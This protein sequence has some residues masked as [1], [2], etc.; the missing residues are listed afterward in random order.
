MTGL[1]TNL[2]VRYII[3]DHPAQ[4]IK[5]TR[6]IDQQLTA[7][8]P[9]FISVASLVEMVWVLKSSYGLTHLQL[10]QAVERLLQIGTLLIQN[11]KEVYSAMLA[12]KSGQGSFAD[13]LIGSL[14]LWAG[15]TSTLTFDKRAS[16]LPGF[17]LIQ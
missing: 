5:A 14:G 12:Q 15:C 13:A 8:E 10:G 6:I 11:E 7:K 17:Q 3:R 4:T 2:L 1:D 16:R 9:G